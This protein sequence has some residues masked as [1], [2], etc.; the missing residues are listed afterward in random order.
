M[1]ND[2]LK[3]IKKKYGEKMMHLCRELFSTI[4]DSHPGVL[5]QILLESFEKR[6]DLYD[7]IVK[8][9]LEIS[10]KNYIYS[11]YEQLTCAKEE[12]RSYVEDPVT[13]MSCAGYTL[14]ECKSEKDI[15]A[16][17]KYYA[18]GEMLCTF[19]QGGRLRNCYVYFAVHRD[20]DILNRCDFK[21]PDRQDEYGTSVL[22]IQF[23]RDKSHTISIKN[24][25]NHTVKN[26]DATFSNNL[27]NIIMGLTKSF[28]DY[29]GMKS[30]YLMSRS[31]E[32]PGYVRASD[33]KFYKYNYEI[34]N[35]YYCPNNVVIDN[36]QIF[37]Y[38]KE[39]YLVMD[40]FILDLVNK[41]F[42]T[43]VDD[44]FPRTIGNIKNIN[45]VNCQD[46][47]I[48]TI[49]PKQ[50]QD[51]IVVLDQFH[52]IIGLTNNNVFMISNNFLRYNEVLE[53]ISLEKATAIG[54]KFLFSNKTMK[55]ISLPNVTVI[56]NDFMLNS[57]INSIS[58]PRV[59]VIGDNFM[60]DNTFLK[61]LVLPEVVLIGQ[62]FL[63]SNY[64]LSEIYAPKVCEIGD[65][66]LSQN[67]NL[68][69]I[70]L[71]EVTMIKSHFCF[72]G[73]SIK[74]IYLPKVKAIGDYFLTYN[75]GVVSLN[76]PEVI[77]IGASF[78]RWNQS[79]STIN[80]PCVRELGETALINNENISYV[81]A[82]NLI[83]KVN[84]AKLNELQAESKSKSYILAK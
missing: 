31:F 65:N 35:V 23:T 7:D 46:K 5:S 10:F 45:I 13:L 19:T 22:S 72:H 74:E 67:S 77:T 69:T 63:Y 66:F 50:G 44:A 11:I 34:D 33:G 52:R 12:T 56:S 18:P 15:Q 30:S 51:I 39:K 32:I 9:Q 24:R 83:N 47:K 58:L 76:L 14:Y 28:A 84:N 41:K 3:I 71:P 1:I 75:Q 49:T 4:M 16:F 29:Y 81:Y 79:I 73:K 54:S 53:N 6:H 62:D 42:I 37:A 8:R 40:Y 43:K 82:P 70:S 61:S 21:K 38:S 48:V 20:A 57:R 78:M 36:F 55:E 68:K 60:W 25:Y 26:P 59:T 17:K 80:L 2:D 64:C 27:D